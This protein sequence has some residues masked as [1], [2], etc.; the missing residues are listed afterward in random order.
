MN[1]VAPIVGGFDS[2]QKHWRPGRRASSHPCRS[3]RQAAAVKFLNDNAFATPTFLLKPEILRRIEPAGVLDRIRTAQ[4]RVL[5][6][7]MNPARFT[8]LVEQE[9]LDGASAYRPVDFLGDLRKGIWSELVA[10]KATIDATRRALQRGYLDQMY[11]KLNGR[12]PATDDARALIRAELRGLQGQ[13]VGAI[14]AATDRATRAHLEDARDQI[15]RAL[16]SEGAAGD[17]RAARVG[18]APGPR[19]HGRGVAGGRADAVLARL[20]DSPGYDSV[21]HEDNRGGC[22][23][24]RCWR[25]DQVRD[26][27]AGRGGFERRARRSADRPSIP[28]EPPVSLLFPPALRSSQSVP[29]ET[30]VHGHVGPVPERHVHAVGCFQPQVVRISPLDVR[31]GRKRFRNILSGRQPFDCERSEAVH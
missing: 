29:G 14:G 27:E 19:R 23:H 17:C 24:P 31:P 3:A 5:T 1:H 18:R 16:E 8:R 20:R 15:A 28:F 12:Q 10:P 13:L 7:L 22:L 30:K 9:A 26:Q 6:G 4:L 25:R 2:Q 21:G 11:E